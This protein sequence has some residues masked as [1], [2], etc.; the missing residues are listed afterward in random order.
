MTHTPE[1][2]QTPSVKDRAKQQ[3]QT[4]RNRAADATTRISEVTKANLKPKPKSKINLGHCA[5]CVYKSV[6]RVD[7][8]TECRRFPPTRIESGHGRWPVLVDPELQW[9]GEFRPKEDAGG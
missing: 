7:N 8:R 5:D 6:D 1:N 4:V 9:C 3:W 2:G